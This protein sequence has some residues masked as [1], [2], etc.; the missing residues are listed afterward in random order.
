[1]LDYGNCWLNNIALNSM[2][3]LLQTVWEHQEKMI[4][5]VYHINH[6]D[7]HMLGKKRGNKI[8]SKSLH[9]RVLHWVIPVTFNQMTTLNQQPMAI[10]MFILIVNLILNELMQDEKFRYQED[11]VSFIISIVK[12]VKQT[13][14]TFDL[15]LFRTGHLMEYWAVGLFSWSKR[16]PSCTFNPSSLSHES[17]SQQLKRQQYP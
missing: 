2:P 11:K 6:Q 10:Q 5:M 13:T 3:E 12:Y 1:M 4:H 14:Y 8:T 16:C 15:K 7:D 17:S 9:L